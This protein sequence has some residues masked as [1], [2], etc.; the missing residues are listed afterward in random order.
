MS[1]NELVVL[2]LLNQKPM[3]GYQL[4]QE[5]ERTKME[6]WAEVNL[7]S[8]YN[9]LNRL[10]QSKMVKARKERPGRMPERS[11]YRITEGGREK[12]ACLLEQVLRDNRIRPADLMLGIFFIQGLPKRKALDCL[13]S[14]VEVMKELL[15]GLLKAEKDV[16][17]NTP[18]PWAFFMRGTI[19]HLKNGITRIDD[20]TRYIQ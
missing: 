9:T 1:K 17:G 16:A 7:S 5:I 12:L 18:F 10:E 15:Q 6:I 11:V 4:H 8:I 14:K 3:Y 20:L 13:K 2:G 19:D